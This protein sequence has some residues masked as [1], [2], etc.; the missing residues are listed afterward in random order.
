MSSL[1]ALGSAGH[2]FSDFTPEVLCEVLHCLQLRAAAQ[3]GAASR[4]LHA[5]TCDPRLW[6]RWAEMLGG[7]G[8]K[9][10]VKSRVLGLA[11]WQK[12]DH[13]A[14]QRVPTSRGFAAVAPLGPTTA[15]LQGGLLFGRAMVDDVWLLTLRQDDCEWQELPSKTHGIGPGARA[16]QDCFTLQQRFFVVHGGKRPRGHRDNDTFVL[17]LGNLEA[18]RWEE[19]STGEVHDVRRPTAR[20]HHTCTAVGGGH[21]ALLAGGQDR[22]ISVIDDPALLSVPSPGEPWVWRLSACGASTPHQVR[23]EPQQGLTFAAANLIGQPRAFH[24]AAAVG[25]S[26]IAVFGGIDEDG[27]PLDDL[28]LADCDTERGQEVRVGPGPRPAGRCRHTMTL[29]PG[30]SRLLLF[31][32][33]AG[34]QEHF[35]ASPLD[36]WSI[37]LGVEASSCWQQL[38]FSTSCGQGLPSFGSRRPRHW[39]LPTLAFSDGQLLVMGGYRG[40][41]NF[42]NFGDP[43][44]ASVAVDEAAGEVAGAL[45]AL[46]HHEL[47]SSQLWRVASCEQAALAKPVAFVQ[48]AESKPISLAI[49]ETVGEPLT[50]YSLAFRTGSEDLQVEDVV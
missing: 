36:L 39:L 27:D 12:L 29:A 1:L 33:L 24:A 21:A 48:C 22:T 50:V 45:V 43:T 31:G 23:Q 17:D 4:H 38:S 25:R 5:A 42:D 47:F 20:F 6:S 8:G 18:P 26:K 46:P 44:L 13:S 7:E 28:W 2:Q 49:S 40:G 15:V 19:V 34:T 10:A 41:Q 14:S 35:R 32:G 11:T 3:V 37:D 16:F 30:T 9:D